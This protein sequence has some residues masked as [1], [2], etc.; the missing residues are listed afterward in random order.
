MTDIDDSA[1]LDVGLNVSTGE[2]AT[3]EAA[4]FVWSDVSAI[5]HLYTL[6]DDTN[7][8][9]DVPASSA[10]WTSGY[11]IKNLPTAYSQLTA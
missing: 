6:A 1:G 2:D 9:T 11:L 4:A 3:E 8:G 7:G 5:N 10:D